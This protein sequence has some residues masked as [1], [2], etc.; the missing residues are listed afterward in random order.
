[1]FSQED[2]SDQHHDDLQSVEW[3][4]LLDNVPD[5]GSGEST[6]EDTDSEDAG[7]GSDSETNIDDL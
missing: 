7:T 1:M 3:M 2:S 4:D 5:Y 6:A